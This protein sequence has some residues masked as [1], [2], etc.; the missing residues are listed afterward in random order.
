[1]SQHVWAERMGGIGAPTQSHQSEQGVKVKR[2][3]AWS[4]AWDLRSRWRGR[5]SCW[6]ELGQQGRGTVGSPGT[7]LSVQ[8]PGD[9]GALLRMGPADGGALAGREEGAPVQASG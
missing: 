8:G 3:P 4:P 5:G 1:M 7:K 6:P 9:R 2:N